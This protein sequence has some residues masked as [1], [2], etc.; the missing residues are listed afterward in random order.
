MIMR[1][2]ASHKKAIEHDEAH[3]GKV[4]PSKRHEA[5]DRNKHVPK[6]VQKQSRRWWSRYHNRF[7]ENLPQQWMSENE[8]RFLNEELYKAWRN[9]NEGEQKNCAFAIS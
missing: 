3:K 2:W 6:H 1:Q 5:C 8:I 9:G 4:P 7:R